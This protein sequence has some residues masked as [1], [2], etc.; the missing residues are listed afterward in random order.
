[1]DPLGA[2]TFAIK[3]IEKTIT[4]LRMYRDVP[5]T[6]ARALD[7]CFHMARSLEVWVDVM[8]N[9]DNSPVPERHKEHMRTL[10]GQFSS[11]MH[12]YAIEVNCWKEYFDNITPQQVRE[13]PQYDMRKGMCTI[14]PFLS[15]LIA[16]SNL[17]VFRPAV[18][19]LNKHGMVYLR[20]RSRYVAYL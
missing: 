1:M 14:Q 17:K 13:S 6:I 18:T 10:L 2:A 19:S 9:L 20:A 15:L 11:S 16:S 3:S 5:V 12:S 8:K 7:E 4:I